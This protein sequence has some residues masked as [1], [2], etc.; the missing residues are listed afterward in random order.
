MVCADEPCRGS[1]P[2]IAQFSGEAEFGMRFL[3]TVPGPAVLFCTAT[4]TG[5]A[6]IPGCMQNAGVARVS[7]SANTSNRKDGS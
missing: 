1:R 6:S 3:D 2:L 7:C 5:S 4:P